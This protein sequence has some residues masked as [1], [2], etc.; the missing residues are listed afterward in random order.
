MRSANKLPLL[1]QGLK[2][3]INNLGENDRVA[4]VVYAGASGTVLPSTKVSDKRSILD[5]LNKLQAGGS[6][7]GAE[8]IELAYELASKN[9]VEGGNNRILLASDGDFNVG[10]SSD[11]EMQRL[12]EVNRDKGIYLTVLGF[13][14]G[15]YK[16]SKI[17]SLK[18][19]CG[20]YQGLVGL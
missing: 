6:T 5:A 18:Q 17:A 9:F 14:M 12:I 2:L 13:G 7:A 11:A 3:L 19:L 8:G 4:I 15:N 16:D 20:S 1:K 10:P